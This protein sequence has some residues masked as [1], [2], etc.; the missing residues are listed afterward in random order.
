MKR[1]CLSHDQRDARIFVQRPGTAARDVSRIGA[2]DVQGLKNFIHCSTE[3]LC[4]LALPS[5]VILIEVNN[6]AHTPPLSSPARLASRPFGQ[7][8][9]QVPAGLN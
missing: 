2:D 3:N 6:G 1:S 5:V 8:K 4:N 9:T 7:P